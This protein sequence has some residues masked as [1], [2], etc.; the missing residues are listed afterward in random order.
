MVEPVP[1]KH[2]LRDRAYGRKGE[3]PKSS[4]IPNEKNSWLKEGPPMLGLRL[5]R[6]GSGTGT[7]TAMLKKKTPGR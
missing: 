3:T 5:T 1:G 2:P 4:A 7:I 6:N